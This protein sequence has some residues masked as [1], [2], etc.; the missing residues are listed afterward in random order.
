MKIIKIKHAALTALLL[1]SGAVTTITHANPPKSAD[2]PSAPLTGLQLKQPFTIKYAAAAQQDF[3]DGT[4][5]QDFKLQITLSYDGKHLLYRNEDLVTH[6]T[7][8][9]LYDGRQL[10]VHKWPGLSLTQ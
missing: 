1:L 2:L 10:P 7:H 3:Q 6:V 5:I 9:V 8:T 4:G